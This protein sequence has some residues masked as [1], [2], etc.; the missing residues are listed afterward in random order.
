MIALDRETVA[1]LRSHRGAQAQEK[2]L[3][4]P[5]Y[6]DHGLV[7]CQSNGRPIDPDGFSKKFRQSV[8]N[9]GL[10]PIRL[11]DAR[12]THA[13]LALQAGIHVKVVSERLGHSSIA[14][15]LDTYSHAIPAMH[16]AAAEQ[17]AA[18]FASNR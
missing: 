9:L 8:Q 13:T 16:E 7:I 17:I 15:T 2:L 6:E 18:L 3:L 14:L 11:H 4:G 12:H 5:A 1:V 10:P